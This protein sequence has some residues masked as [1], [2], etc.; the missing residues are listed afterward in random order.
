[1]PDL[2]AQDGGRAIY[3]GPTLMVRVEQCKMIIMTPEP[4]IICCLK[5]LTLTARSYLLKNMVSK[6]E[7]W[8]LN[9]C[10]S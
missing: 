4:T 1:M 8:G 7:V 9:F 10:K 5:F 3:F 6:G 2:F